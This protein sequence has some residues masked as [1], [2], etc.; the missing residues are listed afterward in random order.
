MAF[1]AINNSNLHNIIVNHA[2]STK[3]IDI[4]IDGVFATGDNY[5]GDLKTSTYVTT[6]YA[7]IRTGYLCGNIQK[8]QIGEETLTINEI[9]KRFEDFLHTFQQVETKYYR[10]AVE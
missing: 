10:N 2:A 5:T 8:V 3:H 1:T 4:H 7:S 9:A 6:G